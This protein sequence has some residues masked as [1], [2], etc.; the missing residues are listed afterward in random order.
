MTQNRR[1]ARKPK[2]EEAKPESVKEVVQQ[3][4]Q[5]EQTEQ[6]TPCICSGQ[7]EQLLLEVQTLKE[8]IEE[9]KFEISVNK[10]VIQSK[11]DTIKYLEN[12]IKVKQES[13]DLQK[14]KA[15]NLSRE[16]SKVSSF[17]RWLYGIKY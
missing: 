16:L 8:T 1:G 13:L 12:T 11:T 9:Q 17:G 6:P 7:Y 14:T 3:K 2:L 15:D 4:I 5:E 10:A